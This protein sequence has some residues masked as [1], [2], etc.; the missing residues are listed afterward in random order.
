MRG[1]DAVKGSF[2]SYIGLEKRVRSDH[3]LR[4]IREIANA[5]LRSL[6]RDFA[7]LHADR[8]GVD[9]AGAAAAGAVA[10]GLLFDSLGA[11]TGRADR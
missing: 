2:S 7:A 1:D 6:M 11:A 9:P 5:A 3:P 8:A 4:L 10:A